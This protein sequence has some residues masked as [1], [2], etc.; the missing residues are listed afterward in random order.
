MEFTQMKPAITMKC[1][2]DFVSKLA[3]SKTITEMFNQLTTK[4][5]ASLA[6]IPNSLSMLNLEATMIS[7]SKLLLRLDPLKTHTWFSPMPEITSEPIS[8]YSYIWLY[9]LP[10]SGSLLSWRRS[11]N[12][13]SSWRRETWFQQMKMASQKQET[14]KCRMI[15]CENSL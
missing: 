14:S 5:V 6:A 1:S 13:A 4:K 9:S 11:I 15:L 3:L 10:L 2:R 7:K 8:Q 12:T